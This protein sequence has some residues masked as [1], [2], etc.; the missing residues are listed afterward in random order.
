M[1]GLE[2]SLFQEV[3]V[4]STGQDHPLKEGKRNV[5]GCPSFPPSLLLL[6]LGILSEEI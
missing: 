3:V 1:V 4:N 5:S 6:L 2:L